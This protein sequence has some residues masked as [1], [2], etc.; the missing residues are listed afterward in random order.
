MRRKPALALV[1]AALL[2]AAPAASAAAPAELRLTKYNRVY[3]DLAGELAPIEAP[4]VRIRMSSPSQ[5]IVVKDNLARLTPL[6]GGR[7]DGR[8]EIELLGKGQLVIDV[9][10]GQSTQR[11]EDEV[12][13]PRQRLAIEGVAHI[14][15]VADGYRVTPERLPPSLPIEIRSHLVNQVVDLCGGAALLTLGALDCAPLERALER[16]EIPLAGAA[17]EIFLPDAELT[18][19][20]RATLD[21][22][23][24]AP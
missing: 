18:G 8:V 7:F 22:L 23:L 19:D 10:L 5:A 24:A 20:E 1:S 9:D 12:F 17:R 13:L 14:A 15:R 16:P 21:R 6:G 3:Q 4:P 11:L 2:A